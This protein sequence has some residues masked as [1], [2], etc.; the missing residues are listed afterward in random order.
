[1]EGTLTAS[2]VVVLYVA[3]VVSLLG[4]ITAP[5]GGDSFFH[6]VRTGL[7]ACECESTVAAGDKKVAAVVAV[8]CAAVT[9]VI[10]WMVA[11]KARIISPVQT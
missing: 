3:D 7:N 1:M 8:A 9:A 6:A 11:E 5:I 10:A 4:Q 2:F